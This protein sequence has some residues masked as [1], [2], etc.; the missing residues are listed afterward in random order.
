MPLLSPQRNWLNPSHGYSQALR[1]HSTLPKWTHHRTAPTHSHALSFQRCIYSHAIRFYFQLSTHN[2]VP[3]KH[4]SL[5]HQRITCPRCVSLFEFP[6]CST[7]GLHTVMSM[8]RGPSCNPSPQS[9]TASLNALERYNPSQLKKASKLFLLA[10]VSTNT[11][12]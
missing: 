8:G 2:T 4:S 6:W 11:V 7:R 12:I 9:G 3:H 1:I 5:A 10:T